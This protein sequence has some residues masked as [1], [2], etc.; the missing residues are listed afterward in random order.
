MDDDSLALA[1]QLFSQSSLTG[2][3]CFDCGTKAALFAVQGIVLSDCPGCIVQRIHKLRSNGS[4]KQ[5]MEDLLWEA[6]LELRGQTAKQRN[7]FQITFDDFYRCHLCDKLI[8]GQDARYVFPAGANSS[9]PYCVECQAVLNEESAPAPVSA[10][11]AVEPNDGWED[12]VGIYESGGKLY[13][14]EIVDGEPTASSLDDGSLVSLYLILGATRRS[15]STIDEKPPDPAPDPVQFIEPG[16]IY[17]GAD[18]W[19][20]QTEDP[21][22]LFCTICRVRVKNFYGAISHH[23]RTFAER[24]KLRTDADTDVA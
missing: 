23:A 13:R 17:L 21:A 8:H 6:E 1:R 12:W 16:T 2:S 19:W 3:D 7:V 14:L 9:Y 20:E 11:A 4:Q 18:H 10:P 5:W 24:H 22:W 15:G